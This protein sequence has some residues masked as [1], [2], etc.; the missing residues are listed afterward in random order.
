M[1]GATPSDLFGGGVCFDPIER[2]TRCRIREVI[3]GVIELRRASTLGRARN[4]R[5]GGS[6]HRHGHRLR[7]LAGF[8]GPVEIAVPRARSALGSPVP[9][10]AASARQSPADGQGAIKASTSGGSP[11]WPGVASKPI[12]RA[13]HALPHALGR[14]A[15]EPL[16]QCLARAVAKRRKDPPPT[17]AKHLDDAAAHTPIL[18]PRHDARAM[19]RHQRNPHALRLRQP[20]TLLPTPSS[21]S[22]CRAVSTHVGSALSPVLHASSESAVHLGVPR[23]RCR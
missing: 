14:P 21:Q 12:G 4:K 6:G 17:R 16:V 13:E 1:E 20:A 5:G 8:F 11:C 22:V 19:S 18:N 23:P 15:H 3:E 2:S 10:W 7:R 9:A